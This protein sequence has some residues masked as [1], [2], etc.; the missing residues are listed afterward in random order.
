MG[1][2]TTSMAELVVPDHMLK[3][4]TVIYSGGRTSLV[5]PVLAGP[6]VTAI[7]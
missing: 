6:L 3:I 2:I 5:D 1:E 4:I 7:N